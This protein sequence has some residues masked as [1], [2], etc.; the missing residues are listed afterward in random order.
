MQGG[1]ARPSDASHASADTGEAAPSR[2][3]PGVAALPG[4]RLTALQRTDQSRAELARIRREISGWLDDK[5]KAPHGKAALHATRLAAL[6][7]ILLGAL[8]VLDGAVG[9]VDV[10]SIPIWAVYAECRRIDESAVWLQRVWAYYRE[11][12]DQREKATIQDVLSAADELVWSCY[13]QV[14]VEG[15]EVPTGVAP[16]PA[17][18]AYIDDSYAPATWDSSRLSPGA[19]REGRQT[20]GLEAFLQTLPVGVIQL[21]PWCIDAPWNL[22]FIAHEVG[23]NIQNRLKLTTSFGTLLEQAA[24]DGTPSSATPSRWAGWGAEIFADIYSAA[25][26]GDAAAIALRELQ[27]GSPEAMATSTDAYP[28]PLMRLEIIHRTATRLGLVA[29]PTA[30]TSGFGIAGPRGAMLDSDLAVLDRVLD[31]AS[32]PLNPAGVTFSSLAGVNGVRDDFLKRGSFWGTAL[33]AKPTAPN[34]G[35]ETARYVI[36]GA[37]LA[38]QAIAATTDETDR[39]AALALLATNTVQTL[40]I[41]GPEGTRAGPGDASFADEGA[42]LGLELLGLGSDSVADP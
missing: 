20:A 1:Q 23:H 15:A 13:Q 34:R 7:Q 36:H 12:F 42:R 2:H 18:L 3:A 22:A 28:A 4:G 40:T 17:P 10:A 5:E 21:P 9:R 19:L 35:L 39:A 11:K 27:V 37:W 16:G 30:P 32:G 24:A 25:M 38:W 8:D 6:R 33:S 26:I 41:S 31:A 29:T 14:F